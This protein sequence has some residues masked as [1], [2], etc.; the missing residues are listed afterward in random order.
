ME[1]PVLSDP[2]IFPTEEV[3][4]AHLGKAKPAFTSLFEFNHA[5]HPDFVERW[6]Y[7]NDG[8]TW[9]LNVS[10]KKKTLFWLSVHDG[11]FRTSFYLNSKLER[12]VLKS[13]IPKELKDQYLKTAGEKFRAVRVVV[14]S[15]NDLD[16]Y[17]EL[18]SIKMLK[19]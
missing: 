12:D 5:N 4:S 7:Y 18:L 17:K 8:K 3:L 6:R 2:K 11:S 14:K 13:K 9:L 16:A 1:K 19:A 10:R 15:K